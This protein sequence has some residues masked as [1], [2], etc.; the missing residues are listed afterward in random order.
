MH[1]EPANQPTNH[2]LALPRPTIWSNHLKASH[3]VHC[4]PIYR[5]LI[6]RSLLPR[7]GSRTNALPLCRKPGDC[8]S[9]TGRATEATRWRLG[10]LAGANR[11]LG[12]WDPRL[13]TRS[14]GVCV[15]CSACARAEHQQQRQDRVVCIPGGLD[16]EG[17]FRA[18]CN[19]IS[20]L[21]RG[22]LHHRRQDILF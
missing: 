11:N 13:G 21:P 20:I 12:R 10:W 3:F 8:N 9:G 14:R 22:E 17:M 16:P 4:A 2:P 18:A 15:T 1:T 5:F 7:Q 19:R 6:T